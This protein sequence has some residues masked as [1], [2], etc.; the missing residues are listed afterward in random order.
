MTTR[1]AFITLLGGANQ[2]KGKDDCKDNL[3]ASR[4]LARTTVTA[5]CN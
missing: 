5:V 4:R 3:V 2:I 1:R